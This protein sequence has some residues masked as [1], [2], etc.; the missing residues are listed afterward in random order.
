MSRIMSKSPPATGIDLIDEQHEVLH[1]MIVEV[2]EAFHRGER[3][4]LLVDALT[5]FYQ[6]A[7]IHFETEEA[8]LARHVPER[9]D[10][11]AGPHQRLL[12]TLRTRILDYKRDGNRIPNS[13]LD[14]L[15]GFTIHHTS[16]SDVRDFEAVLQS[17]E[18]E[19]DDLLRHQN[20]DPEVAEP[21]SSSSPNR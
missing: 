18:R 2:E 13:V 10:A 8:L 16:Q 1:R 20:S 19:R 15:E 12:H 6:Y 21:C 17:M 14:L 3:P 7:Q 9:L 4:F 11:H 5:R